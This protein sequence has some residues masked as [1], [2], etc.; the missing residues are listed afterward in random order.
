MKFI[1][2]QRQNRGNGSAPTLRFTS[3]VAAACVVLVTPGRADMVTEWNENMEA[4]IRAAALPVPAHGRTT[5][6]VHAAIYDAV[7]GIARKY[8]P[9]HVT[10]AGPPGAR[11]EAAAAQ[12]AYTALLALFPT[13]KP[14]LDAELAQSISE[15]PGHQGNSQA[16]AR[17]RAWGQAVADEIIAWRKQD[18][19]STPVPGYFGGGAPGIWRS[20][21]V[22]GFPDGTLPAIFPQL[23]VL[24][25]FAMTSHDQFRPGPPPALWSA[26]YAA[27]VNET[28]LLGAVNS[29]LRTAKQTQLALLW[30]AIGV[31]EENRV[32]RQV[33]PQENSLVDNARLFALVNIVAA[34]TT[35]AGFDSKYT[36]NLWRPYHAI[37]LA[38]SAGNPAIIEDPTW[39]A[40]VLAPRFQEYVANHAIITGGVM[41]ALARL[42]G[43]NHTFVLSAPGFPSFT[44][45]FNSFSDA[46][47]QVKEARIWGGIHFRNSCELGGAM[48]QAIADYV[49]DNFL[50]PLRDQDE[51]R[52]D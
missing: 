31:N 52:G 51:N 37:R 46:A 42:L 49:L 17:G 34:D 35:I 21:A 30:Q 15:I 40:L 28:K 45:P 16:I 4:A 32:I 24:L 2:T 18:G 50:L 20:I 22:P 13:Q 47:A 12:A 6:T 48:G 44:Y 1:T 29:T 10:D 39:T 7:N 19:F 5:A 33:V 27:D 8:A 9:Y 38:N 36:Y 25:P 14:V 41:H 23:A 3:A 43:D 26:Q 11:P